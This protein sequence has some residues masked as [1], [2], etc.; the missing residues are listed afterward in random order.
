MIDLT[1]FDSKNHWET[2]YGKKAADDVSWYQE[3]PSLSMTFIEQAAIDKTNPVID[4]G[5]G[6]TRLIGALLDAG[7]TSIT[8]LDIS[9]AALA[10]ARAQLSE[11]TARVQWI[12][13][14]VR[15]VQLPPYHYALWHDRAVL[16]FLTI[17]ADYAAYVRTLRK[18][19]KP[20]GQAIIATFAPDG[21][22]QCSN[23]DVMRYSPQ[24]L[25]EL[26]G[27]GFILLETQTETHITPWQSQQQFTW[28]RFRV[29]SCDERLDAGETACGDLIMLIF[30][31]MKTLEPGQV[32]EVIAYDPGS[33]VD[34]PAW[35]RQTGNALL[36]QSLPQM[37]DV[38]MKFYIQKKEA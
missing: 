21:P 1:N 32:L 37:R 20:G 23:L 17:E 2:I 12:A 33:P 29:T 14:D 35:C 25:S 11:H 38:P 34:I 8:A 30:Q 16:H 3:Q 36:Y 26:L 19:V 13:G 24:S 27:E 4:V 10:V 18:A 22:Q 15:Q 7:Y 31:R 28:C 5:S 6:T 9:E